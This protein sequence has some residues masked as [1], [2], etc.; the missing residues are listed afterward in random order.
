MQNDFDNNRNSQYGSEGES[1]HIHTINSDT[2][3]Y[4]GSWGKQL[5][6]WLAVKARQLH[7]SACIPHPAT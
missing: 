2:Q 6:G 3:Q 5:S 1:K 4:S 7:T